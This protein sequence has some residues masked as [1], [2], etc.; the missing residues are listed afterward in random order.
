MRVLCEACGHAQPPDWQPGD[1]CTQCGAV[2]RR[3]KRCHWCARLTPEGRFCRHCGS[4]LVPDAQYGAARWLRHLGADQ[5]VIPD[6]LAAM[7]PEQVDHFTRLYQRHAAVAERHVDDVAFAESYLRQRGWAQSLENELLP[8][9]PLPNDDALAAL[10]Q[11]ARQGTTA[12]EQLLEIRATTP[13][14]TT[15]QLSALARLRLWQAGDAGFDVALGPDLDLAEQALRAPDAAL[16]T[17]AALVLIHWR[18]VV[19]TG[20]LPLPAVAEV[21]HA[22]TDFAVEAAVGLA[23]LAAHRRGEAQ[24]VPLAALAAEDADVAFAAALAHHAPEPL[25]AALPQPG[26]RFAAALT[27]V[28]MNLDF[29]LAPLL[30]GFNPDQLADLLR[31]LAWQKQP[32]PDLRPFLTAA[33]AGQYDLYPVARQA[34]RELL[35]LAPGPADDLARE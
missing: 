4:G 19:S 32:R 5:F 31:V 15:R 20:P 34:A 14:V 35:A 24:P 12:A 22:A 9:L 23:L 16:R 1:L 25:L 13:F 10:A 30:P 21:L 27:L 26:R 17:E 2:A 11:P 18:L 8:R 33:V 6:R 7:D 29:A 28:K 3:E